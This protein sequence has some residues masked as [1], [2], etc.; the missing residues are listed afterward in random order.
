MRS[1][2][3]VPLE[4]K[5]RVFSPMASV[6]VCCCSATSDWNRDTSAQLENDGPALREPLGGI[7]LTPSDGASVLT[8]GL[9]GSDSRNGRFFNSQVYVPSVTIGC[10]LSALKVKVS[11]RQLLGRLRMNRERSAGRR[12]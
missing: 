7:K 5:A 6:V 3:V 12:S 10:T 9:A 11:A 4:T 8:S 1:N 2:S